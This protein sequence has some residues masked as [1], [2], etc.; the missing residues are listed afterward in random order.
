[1]LRNFEK[2]IDNTT[3][4]KKNILVEHNLLGQKISLLSYDR[5]I[6]GQTLKECVLQ[7]YE[8]TIL[9]NFKS[10]CHA[11]KPMASSKTK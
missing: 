10:Y 2:R 7:C 11:R 4:I 5:N 3:L 1:M 8:S 9:H 6:I